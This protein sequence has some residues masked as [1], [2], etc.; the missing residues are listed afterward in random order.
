MSDVND[1]LEVM[2]VVYRDACIKCS[3]DV[4]DL[5]DLETIRSRVEKEGLSFLTIVL[6]QFAKAFERSLADGNIDSK[7]FSGFNKCLLRDEQGKPVGHG[8]IPAFLQGMLSQVFDRKTG[9][10]ITY[11]PPNTNTNGVR[12]AASDIPTVVESI[13]QICRV[14][15][16]VEL[17]CTPK[18]VRAA[19]D[20]F[21]EIEQDLQTFSVPA[22]DEAKFLAASR[23]LWDNMV[24][25][26]SV[27]TVQP[28]HGPGATAERISGNQK[29]VW[30]RWHDRLE[31]YLPLIGNGYPLGLPEHSEELEI[32]T[33]VPEYDE[34]PVRVITVPKTLKSPRVI[35]VEPVCMQYVQQGIR[36]YLYRRIESYWLT[37]NRINFR[38]QSIN[39]RQALL[40]SRKGRLATIDLSEASDRVPLGLAIRMFDAS[41]DLKDSILACRS[42]RAQLPDGRFID[43]LLKFASMGSALCFPIEAMYFYT[44]CVVAMLESTGLSYTQRNIRKVTRKV[45]VY[46]DD[47]VVPS[48]NADV[49]LETL[50]KY[51]CKVNVN[52]TFCTGMF[53]ESCGVDAYAGYEVTPTYI[54][55]PRPKNKQ[56]HKEI[57]SWCAT[58][59][60]FYLKGYW[61]TS[62]LLFKILEKYTGPLPYVRETSPLL[63][64]YSYLGYESV[65]RFAAPSP[66]V[67]FDRDDWERRSANRDY[68]KI[69]NPTKPYYQTPEVRGWK[70]SPVYRSDELDGWAALTKCLSSKREIWRSDTTDLV[71]HFS[72]RTSL[73]EIAASDLSHLDRSALHGAVTL[74]L[75][76]APA[77]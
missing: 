71:R 44:A 58:A 50:R 65:G 7:C 32:V 46:G 34:Q 43:P 62:T 39:Q 27:T 1:Y 6:P 30:R 60:L 15:A 73:E 18:R 13:R 42:T 47:I 19:L 49:V 12:G 57:V 66:F 33:I 76:W 16:K 63:G 67:P 64:R 41:P 52:K 74:K 25:D 8:A 23:L 17:A 51:N 54:R 26:F 31:P 40:G 56:Q 61:R 55:Q 36:S 9:E 53:R 29:Y 69:P 28:K 4:F 35:A 75:R 70:P 21:M 37:R 10:I 72:A 48:A 38:K 24:S 45:Y 14:F 77:H 68:S 5:R 59:N 3:A 2:D 11:E 22:E 20:S